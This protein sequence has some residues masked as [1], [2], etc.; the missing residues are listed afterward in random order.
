MNKISGP[1]Y[2]HTIK[3]LS[4]LEK[5][6]EGLSIINQNVIKDTGELESINQTKKIIQHQIGIH[7]KV[8]TQGD[9]QF[10]NRNK[11]LIGQAIRLHVSAV[12]E[13]IHELSA[14][15]K[16]LID[17]HNRKRKE[18]ETKGFTEGE[19]QELLES[20]DDQVAEFDAKIAALEV[21]WKRVKAYSDDK[22]RFDVSLLNGTRLAQNQEADA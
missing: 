2:H 7:N 10:Q 17:N 14:H 11:E 16:S 21:E 18:L 6:L 1:Q 15:R 12:P 8:V 13:E 19:I 3:I 20:I 4:A 5:V 22:P 9:E